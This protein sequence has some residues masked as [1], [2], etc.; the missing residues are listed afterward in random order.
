MPLQLNF[1][2]GGGTK[3]YPVMNYIEEMEEKP[4]CCIYLTDLECYQKDFGT[5]QV[6]TLWIQTRG[7]TRKPVPFGEVVL[8]K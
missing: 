6:E 4:V 1:M 3:F 2:G 5:E 7:N 8:L